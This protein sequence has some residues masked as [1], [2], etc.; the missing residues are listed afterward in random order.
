MN[1]QNCGNE[2]RPNSQFCHVCGTPIEIVNP[3][4]GGN[5]VRVAFIFVGLFPSLVVIY[6]LILAIISKRFS[7]LLAY[8]LFVVAS[9]LT[10]FALIYRGHQWAILPTGLLII[11]SSFVKPVILFTVY[12]LSIFFIFGTF[13]SLLYIAFGIHLIRS[14]DVSAFI[15]NRARQAA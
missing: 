11:I 3:N 9:A 12:K 6:E 15:K 8:D 13:T 4:K 14:K 5:F 10:L 2:V 1:C 7:P